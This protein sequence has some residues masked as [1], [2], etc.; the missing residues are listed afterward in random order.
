MKYTVV[1]EDPIP[2]YTDSLGSSSVTLDIAGK[3]KTDEEIIQKVGEIIDMFRADMKNTTK[4]TVT[5]S[6]HAGNN[7]MTL[8][9]KNGDKSLSN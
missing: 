1:I 2:P 9:N 3:E 6:D 8:L 4:I 7:I 5:V